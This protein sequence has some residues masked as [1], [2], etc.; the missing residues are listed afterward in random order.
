MRILSELEKDVVAR[1]CTL[2]D[3]SKDVAICDIITYFCP[4]SLKWDENSITIFFDTDKYQTDYVLNRLITIICLFEYLQ[5]QSL[6][7]VFKRT[8][9]ADRKELINVRLN[10]VKWGDG[11]IN[12]E[13][14]IAV[15]GNPKLTIRGKT[16]TFGDKAT[17]VNPLSK[18]NIPWTFTQLVDLYANSVV[19]CTETL[20]HIKNQDFKD[21]ATIQ[22]EENRKQTKKAI[23][24][25]LGIGIGSILVGVII[26]CLTYC[27]NE[28]HHQESLSQTQK[29]VI[30]H[31]TIMPSDQPGNLTV[32]NMLP[33]PIN[34]SLKSTKT[35][36]K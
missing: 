23:K 7:Y 29:I 21:D 10:H 17:G 24:I 30:V 2:K 33:K 12:E 1:L 9:V 15:K 5:T 22:Y 14:E 16:Y 20:R 18:V 3:T 35:K 34:D 36:S 26:G 27:Q 8:N 25:S 13:R 32:N 28:R 31:D 11:S 4:C 19:F 6:I